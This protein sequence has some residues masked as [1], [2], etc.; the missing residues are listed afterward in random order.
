MMTADRLVVRS[1][2]VS[3]HRNDE[4]L[5]KHVREGNH[6]EGAKMLTRHANGMHFMDQSTLI[7]S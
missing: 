5:F 3:Y 2:D 7:C 1:L 4:K 6:R